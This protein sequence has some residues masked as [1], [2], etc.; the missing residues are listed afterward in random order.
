MFI[1]TKLWNTCHRSDLV[2]PACKG[3]LDRLQIDYI[4]LYLVH[5]PFAYKEDQQE[6][7]PVD[8]KGKVIY[9]DIDYLDTWKEMEKCVEMGLVKS[10]GIS[11]FNSEQIERLLSSSKI[12][13]VMN[14]IEAHPNLN[15]KRLINFCKERNIEITAY[16]PLG[17]PAR[18][19]AKPGDP[20]LRLSDERLIEIAKK[21]NKTVPQIIF[22][23]LIHIGT[24]PIPKSSNKKRIQ[25]NINIFDFQLT[26]DE[27]GFI[28]TFDCNG[29]I[30]PA[31]G[32]EDHK[33]Y[34]FKIPF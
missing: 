29:R 7:F 10:I 31:E 5:W 33:Y 21:Y 15:N 18:P 8:D 3:S 20:V 23:Y 11:N 22:R 16:S 4:D 34:P 13:P 17:S 24:I 26:K 32:M 6:L 12:K 30:C 9:S 14:Q 25:E 2:I 19:W 28:D 1:T 27:I